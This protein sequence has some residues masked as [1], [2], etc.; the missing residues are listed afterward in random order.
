M[1]VHEKI[2]V[3][4]LKPRNFVL[5]LYNH[6]IIKLM[7]DVKKIDLQHPFYSYKNEIRHMCRPLFQAIPV[8][9]FTYEKYYYD[10]G[11][12]FFPYL[13]KL[14]YEILQV[15]H[16]PTAKELLHNTMH[17]TIL[18]NNALNPAPW[19][20][21]KKALK[22]KLDI[23]EQF[24]TNHMIV[25]MFNFAEYAEMFF[26]GVGEKIKNYLDLFIFNMSLFEKFCIYF[27]DTAADIIT[28]LEHER[29]RYDYD[30]NRIRIANNP[31]DFFETQNFQNLNSFG[32]SKRQ[33]E[34]LYYLTKGMS[35]KQIAQKLRISPRTIEHYLDTVKVKLGCVNRFDLIE[36]MSKI[37][38]M[39]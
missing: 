17:Y 2:S 36:K 20:H 12:L 1:G 39:L 34:C 15:G 33:N 29:V 23:A 30:S 26:F 22:T 28:K 37:T 19:M 18:S 6:D 27:R 8:S 3:L 4:L 16:L 11:C 25:L 35:L 14:D 7:I 32:F 21:H 5:F 38:I 13:P 31:P 9:Y 24:G 10:G